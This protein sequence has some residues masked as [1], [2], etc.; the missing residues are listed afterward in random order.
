MTMIGQNGK[1]SLDKIL[2]LDSSFNISALKGKDNQYQKIITFDYDSHKLL[3]DNCITHDISDNYVDKNELNF[4]QKKS[5]EL[6]KWH[7]QKE[8]RK[9]V[10]Y[11]GVNLGNLLHIEFMDFIVGFLKKFYELT[12]LIPQNPQ[13]EVVASPGLYDMVQI[14]TNCVKLHEQKVILQSGDVKYSYRFRNKSF[15]IIISKNAYLKLKN[16]TEIFFQKIFHLDKPKNQNKHIMLIEF[17]PTKYKKF[18]LTSKSTG[19]NILLYNRR[20]PTI[21]NFESF[22]IIR[23]SVCR[24]PN[25]NAFFDNVLLDSIRKKQTNFEQ[26]INHVLQSNFFE[27]FFSINNNSFWIALRPFFDD[28]LKQRMIEAIN[29]IEIVKKLF[30][31]YKI[32]PV[33]ILSEIGFTEQIVM[34]LARKNNVPVLMMQ[35]G[36]PYETDGAFERNN[37]LGFFPNFSDYMITW[38]HT[39][40]DY[41]EHCG[42]APNKIKA[43]GCTFYDTLFDRDLSKEETILLATSPPMKDLIH[44]NLVETNERYQLAIEKIC[45]TV[46]GLNQRLVVKLHPSLVDF[47]IDSLTKKIDKKILVI[48][49][50]SII[51]FIKNCKLMLTFDLSTTILEAQ[52]LKKPVISISLKDY[53]FGESQTFKTNACVSINIEQ[54]EETLKKI[55]TD[56]NYKNEMIKNG[57]AFVHK[58]ISNKERSTSEILEFLKQF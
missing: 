4:L 6:S 55:L 8:I 38:G 27:S 15:S 36:V 7:S 48:T 35:H 14:F 30:A 37:L 57:D 39:T 42:I 54:L 33:L 43:L 21:W 12:K 34:N 50:G 11:D 52:I 29:E 18:F 10:E 3:S 2:L 17:D 1:D 58:Y 24:I 41:I 45:K 22:N 32:G 31:K 49:S 51:P 19:Q 9:F 26:N 13:F 16:I 53:G 20:W 56:V 44:D 25:I 5:Y 46:I 28:M 40:K 47:D 23:K